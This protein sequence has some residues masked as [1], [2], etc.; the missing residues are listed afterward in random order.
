MN[1]KTFNVGFLQSN[2]YLVSKDINSKDAILFDCGDLS[3]ELVEYIEKNNI[4]VKAIFLTHGHFDHIS[5]VP[6][7]QKKGAKVYSHLNE[8]DKIECKNLDTNI[9][10]MD[11]V[12]FKADFHVKDEEEIKISDLN[13]KVLFTPGH[14]SGSCVYL[15]EDTALFTGDTIFKESFGRYDFYDSNFNDLKKSLEKILLLKKDYTIYPGHGEPTS[16]FYEKINNPIKF[17]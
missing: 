5:A 15:V 10:N 2:I 12:P 8:D 7:F 17:Y 16:V 11:L 6:Y 1:I 4:N 9:Y 13:V 14:S 3:D